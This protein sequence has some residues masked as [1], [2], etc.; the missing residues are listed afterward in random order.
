MDCVKSFIVIIVGS[1]LITN[2]FFIKYTSITIRNN[3]LLLLS[4][5]KHIYVSNIMNGL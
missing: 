2:P 3:F 1:F 5:I 4:L